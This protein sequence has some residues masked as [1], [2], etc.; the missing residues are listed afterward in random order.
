MMWVATTL[1]GLVYLDPAGGLDI[2]FQHSLQTQF[3]AGFLSPSVYS[4]K[5]Q[6]E[7]SMSVADSNRLLL[8][9]ALNA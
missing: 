1:F 8:D 2:I 9:S 4:Y 6:R 3:H 5:K 7:K